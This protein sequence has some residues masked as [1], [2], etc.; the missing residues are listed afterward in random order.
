MTKIVTTIWL[1]QTQICDRQCYI[2]FCTI[3]PYLITY[4]DTQKCI[5]YITGLKPDEYRVIMIITINQLLSSTDTLIQQYVN[6]SQIESIYILCI[7]TEIGIEIDDKQ[8]KVRGIYTELNLLCKS[9]SHYL[10]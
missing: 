6:L 10:I 9:L 3:D 7:S 2:S 4:R 5:D 8:S 1:D